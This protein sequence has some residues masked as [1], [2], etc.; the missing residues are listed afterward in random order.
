MSEVT[1]K[2][3]TEYPPR[4][5][6]KGF[7][8]RVHI[9]DEKTGRLIKYQ[10]YARHSHGTDLLFERPIGSGNCFRENGTECGRWDIKAWKQTHDTHIETAPLPVNKQE[11]QEQELAAL[12]AELAALKSK[13]EPKAETQSVAQKK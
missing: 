8:D 9:V 11:A 2:K 4:D 10:P 6:S 7:D 5:F 1:Q 3:I 13:N 12:R